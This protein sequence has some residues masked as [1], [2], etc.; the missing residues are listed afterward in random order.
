MKVKEQKHIIV[1]EET[2]KG[3]DE[4]KEYPR[5]TYDDT[6]KRMIGKNKE[7]DDS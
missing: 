3:L 5:E 1:S 4:L 2:K 6:I 7:G